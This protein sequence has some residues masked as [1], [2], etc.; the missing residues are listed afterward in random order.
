M[1]VGGQGPVL[2]LVCRYLEQVA[3]KRVATT[4]RNEHGLAA[5]Q[6]AFIG[7]I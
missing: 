6:H 7:E 1:V 4:V 3:H 2:P 5:Y